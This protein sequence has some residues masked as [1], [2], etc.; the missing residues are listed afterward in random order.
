MV[1]LEIGSP[2]GIL[3]QTRRSK[4]SGTGGQPG[5]AASVRGFYVLYYG[6]IGCLFPYLNL[7]YQHLGLTG[8]QIGALAAV[9]TV[10]S[11]VVAPLWAGVGDARRQHS[12]LLAIA[13][14]GSILPGFLLSVAGGMGWFVALTAIYALFFGPTHALIDSIALGSAKA[15]QRSFGELRA[16]GTLGY[17]VFAW[18]VGAIIQRTGLKALF[19]GYVILMLGSFAFALRLPNSRLSRVPSV[20][21]GLRKMLNDGPFLQFLAGAFVLS[22][23]MGAANS[24][25]PLY[26]NA[27]G[28]SAGLLGLSQ[29]LAAMSEIPVVF[30]SGALL[31][32]IGTRGALVTAAAVFAVRWFLYART[33]S[34]YAAVAV[35]LLHGL[36][37]GAFMVAGVIYTN[38]HAPENLRAT[39]QS[40]LSA[41]TLAASGIA[42]GLL[43]GSLY[44]RLGVAN[45]FAICALV[46]VTACA[47][48]LSMHRTERDLK[49]VA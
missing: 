35:Q 19:Y 11:L 32:R 18:L 37:Y 27:I 34:P 8:V 9:S 47:L 16:W 48:F 3:R 45:L 33:A 5:A 39:A 20:S 6:A 40:I 21:G 42:G 14:G 24:F 13:V 1:R 17:I 7:Y 30:F 12:A 41:V 31:H 38:E 10:V 15:R 23:G 43:G 36:S 29:A 4:N 49:A 25:F 46:A 28:G 26:L 2:E 22:I 44:D